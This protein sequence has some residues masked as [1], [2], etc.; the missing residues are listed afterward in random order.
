MVDISPAR[1]IASDEIISPGQDAPPVAAARTREQDLEKGPPFHFEENWDNWYGYQSKAVPRTA[2]DESAIDLA[3]PVT[4]PIAPAQDAMFGV[5]PES[6][7]F[8]YAVT[9]TQAPDMGNVIEVPGADNLYLMAFPLSED[10]WRYEAVLN[11]GETVID[12]SGGGWLLPPERVRQDI[13]KTYMIDLIKGAIEKQGGGVYDQER[14]PWYQTISS[15][16]QKGVSQIPGIPTW[17]MNSALAFPDI[18]YNLGQFAIEGFPE[19][20][21][22][23]KGKFKRYL[24]QPEGSYLGSPEQFSQ[25]AQNLGDNVGAARRFINEATGTLTIPIINEEI[26]LGNLLSMLEFDTTP[27]QRDKAQQYLGLLGE[28]IGGAPFEGVMLGRLM[29]KISKVPGDAT[30]DKLIS[31]MSSYEYSLGGKGILSPRSWAGTRAEMGMGF[32]AGSGMIGALEWSEDWPEWAK[33]LMALGGAFILPPAVS[34]TGRVA[35]GVA[36]QTPFVSIPVKAL[37]GLYEAVHPSG[38]QIA[39]TRALESMG[40]DKATASDIFDVR[41]HFFFAIAQGNHIDQQTFITYTTPQF[42]RREAANIQARLNDPK[43]NFSDKERARLTALL[44]KLRQFA[45]FQEGQFATIFGDVKIAAEVYARQAQRLLERRNK[46]FDALGKII[47]T[48]D[49]VHPISLSPKQRKLANKA[50]QTAVDNSMAAAKQRISILNKGRPK[51]FASERDRANFD[52]MI[53]REVESAEMEISAYEGAMFAAIPG[54][55]TPK[56]AELLIEGVPIGD[57]YAAKLAARKP[58]E[59]KN[60]PAVVHELAGSRRIQKQPLADPEENAAVI[61]ARAQ[62]KTRTEKRNLDEAASK[63]QQDRVAQAKR[64]LDNAKRRKKTPQNKKKLEAAQKEFN[65][66]SKAL[67]GVHTKIAKQDAEIRGYQDVLDQVYLKE[68]TVETPEGTQTVAQVTEKAGVLDFGARI[69]EDGAPIGAAPSDVHR[70]LSNVKRAKRAEEFRKPKNAPRIAEL[71]KVIAELEGVLAGE[72]FNLDPTWLGAAT[73][74]SAVKAGVFGEGPIAQILSKGRGGGAKVQLEDTT[75]V[76][77]PQDSR[78]ALRQLQNAMTR[79]MTGENAPI[80]RGDKTE[81]NPSGLEINPEL[82]QGSEIAASILKRYAEAPPPPFEHIKVLPDA[83]FGGRSKGYR[84]IEGTPE[85]TANIDIVEGVLWDRFSRLYDTKTGFDKSAAREFITN[86]QD[87]IAWLEKAKNRGRVDTKWGPPKWKSPF[88]DINAAEETVLILQQLDPNNIDNT[89]KQ[90]REAGAFEGNP[91][92]TESGLRATLEEAARRQKNLAAFQVFTN[93]TDVGVQGNKFLTSVLESDNASQIIDEVLHVLKQ[94]EL[95]DGTNPSL[96]GFKDIISHAIHS[97]I[98]SSGGDGS[99]IGKIA[100]RLNAHL[101]TTAGK[102]EIKLY[103][104]TKLRK[105]LDRDQPGGEQF[106][107]LLDKV[108]GGPAWERINGDVTPSDYFSTF[109]NNAAEQQMIVSEAALNNIAPQIHFSNEVI[110]NFGRVAGLYF[111]SKTGLINALVAAGIGRRAAIAVAKDIRQSGVERLIWEGIADPELAALLMKKHGKLTDTERG[112]LLQRL[113]KIGKQQVW[114]RNLEKMRHAVED[115]PGA[116]M[117]I[118]KE[119]VD[120]EGPLHAPPETLQDQRKD[121]GLGVYDPSWSPYQTRPEASL[122]ERRNAAAA[123]LGRTMP[124]QSSVLSRVNPVG[125]DPQTAAR[126]QQIFGAMDTVFGGPVTQ[127]PMTAAKGGIASIKPK[128][129]RQMVI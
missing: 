9:G 82:T 99:V 19:D 74:V 126:G 129:P 71:N 112:N 121:R 33:Q 84:V 68:R 118:I 28:I 39:A 16:V 37:R 108:Y 13:Q 2:I 24:S 91:S 100:E 5:G 15:G 90:M 128:K 10:L 70:V 48:G 35:L 58:G 60:T 78:A 51:K 6:T 124:V 73:N 97:R 117:E 95:E 64:E 55:N 120:P 86:N 17:V 21:P 79:L 40:G 59:H 44:P 113:A 125:P 63:W 43:A 111:L 93:G 20:H 50:F 30:R 114:D 101:G 54:F 53:R 83:P 52:E 12:I 49:T 88:R 119:A 96:Q 65:A 29:H 109:A 57:F 56:G 106:R 110:A 42:A 34:T 8:P 31:E 104:Y 32:V 105:L 122:Q 94:G 81:L 7:A 80:I 67:D 38:M 18:F 3:E 76:V 89:L 45:D 103:D 41:D 116:I 26:G 61:R 87:A 69:G 72:N 27:Q 127:A 23:A 46:L 14:E 4:E 36:A 75:G 62:I 85:T 115:K 92:L 1:N 25:L 47:Y 11:D 102:G 22:I 77:L 107:E 66:A 98:R 123:R